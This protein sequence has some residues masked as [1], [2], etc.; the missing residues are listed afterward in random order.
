M[1]KKIFLIPVY[2]DWQ[3]L[4]LLLDNIENE[5]RKTKNFSEIYAINDCSSIVP[6]IKDKN[7]QF[8][9]KIKLLNLNKNLGSQKSIAIGL[10]YLN[11]QIKDR[12]IIIIMDS[13][14]EDDPGNLLKMIKTAEENEDFIITSNRTNREEN[15]IFKFF[16]FLHKILTFIFSL[17]WISFG[18]FNVFHSKNLSKILSN[19][20]SW[21]AFSSCIINNSKIIRLYAQR[22][23][24]YFGK[25]KL[26]FAS[27][28]LHSLRVISALKTRVIKISLAYLSLLIL[29]F[30]NSSNFIYLVLILLIIFFNVLL[31]LIFKIIN[32]EKLNLW[33]HYIKDEINFL[34]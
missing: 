10:K 11:S 16:Y 25:S 4:N 23:K 34:N 13:D 6:E 7:F 26:N 22:K 17:H 32:P 31:L 15:Y 14:G 9:K 19:N 27:L 21:L 29:A 12:A 2:N 5:L 20:L 33:E 30:L 24:R 28:L 3:S 8:I 1:L 18:N